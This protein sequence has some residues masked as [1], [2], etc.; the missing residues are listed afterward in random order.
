M[1]AKQS[2]GVAGPGC[3]RTRYASTAGATSA[4]ATTPTYGTVQAGA[5]P[6]EHAEANSGDIRR[7]AQTLSM[8]CGCLWVEW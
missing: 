1:V 6:C 2:V 4:Y 3:W 5:L 8:C 7:L